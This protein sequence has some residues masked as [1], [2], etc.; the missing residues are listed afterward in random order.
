MDIKKFYIVTDMSWNIALYISEYHSYPY[1]NKLNILK[2]M[3]NFLQEDKVHFYISGT[4]G[5][6]LEW[7]R[8]LVFDWIFTIQCFIKLGIIINCPS[9]TQHQLLIK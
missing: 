8:G 4:Q 5:N 6:Y 3:F 1:G 2:N 7:A 9:P